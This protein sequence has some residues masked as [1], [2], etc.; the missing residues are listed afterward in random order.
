MGWRAARHGEL[1][2]APMTV[3]AQRAFTLVELLVVIGIIALLISILLPALEKARG[4]AN[5]IKCAANLRTIGQGF[6]A[7]I[8]ENKGMLPVAYNYRDG[9]VDPTTGTQTP[10]GPAYGYIHWSSLILDEIP[11][12]SYQ[13]PTMTG[14][15]LPAP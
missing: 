6:A 1:K 14:G 15:G 2:R 11:P 3:R 10:T 7:Y 5:L 12:A 8:A 4:S 13:C 9:T